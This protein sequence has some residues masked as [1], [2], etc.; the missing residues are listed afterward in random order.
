MEFQNEESAI[1]PTG[2]SPPPASWSS[3]AAGSTTLAPATQ[4][5]IDGP[6]Y[7]LEVVEGESGGAAESLRR[8]V[9]ER[10]YREAMR[11]ARGL[12]LAL[13]VLML[14]AVLIGAGI[15]FWLR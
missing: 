13:W 6:V 4:T 11:A 9:A 1:G 2:A 7:G 12:S 5:R 3:S 8:Q 10:T 14:E 15:Y